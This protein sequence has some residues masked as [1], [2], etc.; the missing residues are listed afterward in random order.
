MTRF[1]HRLSKR[2]STSSSKI[3]KREIQQSASLALSLL[4]ICS[5]FMI[6][7]LLIIISTRNQYGH[8]HIPPRIVVIDILILF[9]T[10]WATF[11]WLLICKR[12]GSEGN[13]VSH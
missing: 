1:K 9:A 5:I 11:R 2:S 10:A 12:G 4:I 8:I 7:T 13:N 3:R 6:I